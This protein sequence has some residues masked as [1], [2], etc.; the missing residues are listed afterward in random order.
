[1]PSLG[2]RALACSLLGTVA[3]TGRI[4][5][6]PLVPPP[7]PSPSPS[8]TAPPVI[9]PPAFVPAPGGLRLQTP[10]QYQNAVRALLGE[11][12]AVPAV[13]SWR[14]SIAAA[15][16][17]VS[18]DAVSAYEAAADEAARAVF[19]DDARRR[20][21]VGCE[22]S[23]EAC[24]STFIARFG[25]LA[26]RRALTAEEVSRYAALAVELSAEPSP[27][28]VWFGLRFVEIGRAHV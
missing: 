15:Q 22:P 4:G 25:R 2:L 28:D 21:L 7:P 12:L 5:D 19:T 16:G 3:C 17:G 24:R 11:D 13:G 6:T 14:S 18:F 26:W 23:E 1:M 9:P 20:A 8:A 27:P 10:T